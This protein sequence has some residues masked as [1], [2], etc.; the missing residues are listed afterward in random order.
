MH[1][2]SLAR[3]GIAAAMASLGLAAPAAAHDFF[4][5]P[6]DFT[7]ALGQTVTLDATVSAGFPKLESVVAVDR[8]GARL[9]RTGGS[10]S[11]LTATGTGTA[12]RL[13]YRPQGRGDAVLTV[14]MPPR[15]V[16]YPHDRIGLILAEYHLEGPAAAAARALPASAA[17]QVTS[18]RF[19]KTVLCVV[20][21]A[22][23][24]DLRRPAGLDL[25]FVAGERPGEYILLAQGHPAPSHPVAI[26]DASGKRQ[27][28]R[29]DAGGRLSLTESARGRTMLFAAVMA[30]PPQTGARFRLD[31][32]TL[33]F[34]R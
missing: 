28:A 1:T 5:L 32:T 34:E 10:A 17:L 31:L 22:E 4:L 30:A 16:E 24:D 29:T 27:Q 18:A 14:A 21:C 11:Q 26:I 20:A 25:E 23:T 6:S 9:V 33:T 13:S 3:L 8:M 12:A 2:P 15:D 19:A 7:P